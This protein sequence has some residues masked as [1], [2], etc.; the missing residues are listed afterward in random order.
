MSQIT[1]RGAAKSIKIYNVSRLEIEGLDVEDFN[2]DSKEDVKELFEMVNDFV[3]TAEAD[4]FE[5]PLTIDGID[6]EECAIDI[7]GKKIYPDELELRN[8]NII[9]LLEPLQDA[10]EGDIFYIRSYEG[11]GAWTLES[12]DEIEDLTK[13]SIGYVDCSVMFDQYDVLREGYLDVICDTIIPGDTQYNGEKVEVSEFLFRP[14]QVYGQ[15]YILKK[16]PIEDLKI[17]QK[18]DFGGHSLVDADMDVDDFEAN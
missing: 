12:A 7:D 9:T 17:L 10:N 3:E 5:P 2:L 4:S 15:L 14:Q 11:E 1:I 6:P 16:D 8:K 18:V 13:L